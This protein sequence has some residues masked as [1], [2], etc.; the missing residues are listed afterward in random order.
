MSVIKKNILVQIDNCNHKLNRIDFLQWL[1]LLGTF[2]ANRIEA[3]VIMFVCVMLCIA[4]KKVYVSKIFKYFVVMLICS[5]LIIYHVDYQYT[6]CVQ[7][8]ILL[9]IFIFSYEQFFKFNKNNI[10]ELFKKYIKVVYWICL[11]GLLQELIFIFFHV[12]IFDYVPGYNANHIIGDRLLRITSTLSEGGWLGTALLPSIVYLF[13]YN[14]FWNILGRKKYLILFVSLFTFSPFIYLT[15]F[16]IL[17]LKMRGK[18]KKIK[19]IISLVLIVL[20]GYVAVH[21]VSIDKLDS[22]NPLD[23]MLMRF[24][25]TYIVISRM[26]N[27]DIRDVVAINMNASTAVIASNMY[28]G[29]HAPSRIFGTGIGTNSQSQEKLIGGKFEE[30]SPMLLNSDD[31]YSLFNRILSELGIVGLSL[32]LLFIYKHINKNNLINICFLV[33]LGGLFLRGGNYVLYGTV[34]AHFFYYYTSKFNIEYNNNEVNINNNSNI[35]RRKDYK[36]MS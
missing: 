4:N 9:S 17:A 1:T 22:N 19:R 29:L 6:K 23:S 25:D 31:G 12:N 15:L 26:N 8:I 35:Q 18:F 30:S 21:I 7:Q 24:H 10:L 33:M 36:T 2:F 14:D 28:I 16:V 20:F 3:V 27:S 13:Y 34:F 11:I 5:I 32:Y